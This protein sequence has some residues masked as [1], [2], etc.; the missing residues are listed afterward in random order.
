M[1]Q[2]FENSILLLDNSRNAICVQYKDSIGNY[3]TMKFVDSKNNKNTPNAT[4]E[5]F[6]ANYGSVQNFFNQLVEKGVNE[7][8]LQ[9][10]TLNGS[11]YKAV[12]EPYEFSLKPK[13]STAEPTPT[14]Q[15]VQNIPAPQPVVP[16]YP[17]MPGLN[18][19]QGLG[20]PEIYKIQD[21]SRITEELR[22]LKIKNGV[23]E[24]QN[25]EL[26]EK[27][28]RN[29]L[30]GT[31]QDNARTEVKDILKELVPLAM[32]FANKMASQGAQVAAEGLA[33]PGATDLQKHF[34]NVILKS[35]EEVIKDLFLVSHGLATSVE[36]D[37]E[38]TELIN[39]YNLG[40]NG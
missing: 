1:K 15:P 9:N 31:K 3:Q 37:N 2:L 10:R 36:F 5:I 14:P 17:A 21:H 29:E 25:K 12:G 27:N 33:A 39:K 13:D 26:H 22:D 4:K 8:R 18:G 32:P 35:D 28:L 11:T 7:L 6:V 24:A 38:L 19:F 16:T 23:L 30:L 34:I 20:M 40:Q